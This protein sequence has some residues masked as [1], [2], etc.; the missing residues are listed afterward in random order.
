MERA[1]NPGMMNPENVK[2]QL[3][4]LLQKS[5]LTE[6]EAF[7]L[8][9]ATLERQNQLME[10]ARAVLIAMEAIDDPAFTPETLRANPE[11]MHAIEDGMSV[12]EVYRKYFLRAGKNVPFEES[13]NLG[14]RGFEGGQLTPEE[15]ERISQY[16][17]ESGNIYNMED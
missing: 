16:V 10:R 2:G 15:I 12:G 7:E 5:G 17:S 14:L 1:M 4:L 9:K 11:A 3:D 13:A 6:K 8:L